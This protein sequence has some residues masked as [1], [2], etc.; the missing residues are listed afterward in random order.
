MSIDVPMRKPHRSIGPELPC[1]LLLQR[2]FERSA[3][4]DWIAVLIDE[5]ELV[6]P[7]AYGVPDQA[8]V[9]KAAAILQS[10]AY[11]QGRALQLVSHLVR[12]EGTWQLV[13]LDFGAVAQD[14]GCEFLMC[15]AF[16]ASGQAL[17]VR[18][19]YAEVGFALFN[20][21]GCDP[22][23]TLMLKTAECGSHD[24]A[25]GRAKVPRL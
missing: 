6:V 21:S 10:R 8:A 11:L 9:A 15:F 19:P 1:D 25:S 23:F 20:Q 12:E 14:A 13:T 3:S 2:R 5:R 17:S 24:W 18:S 22:V 4:G 16:Q 7:D